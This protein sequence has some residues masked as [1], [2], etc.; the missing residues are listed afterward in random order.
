MIDAMVI[1][2][3]KAEWFE[4]LNGLKADDA[5]TPGQKVKVIK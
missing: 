3:L 2:D 1:P 5:L 4:A